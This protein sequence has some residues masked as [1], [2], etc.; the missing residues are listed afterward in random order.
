MLAL[1]GESLDGFLDSVLDP[2]RSE[3]LGVPVV[4]LLHPSYQE[5]WLSR[6]GFSYEGYVEELSDVVAATA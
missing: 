5:V 3:T 6:L 1:D 2:R 4:P